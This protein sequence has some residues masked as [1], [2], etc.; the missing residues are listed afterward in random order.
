MIFLDEID[1][2]KRQNKTATSSTTPVTTT[3]ATNTAQTSNSLNF[4]KN[5]SFQLIQLTFFSK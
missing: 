5:Y 2:I 4:L 1:R 3:P